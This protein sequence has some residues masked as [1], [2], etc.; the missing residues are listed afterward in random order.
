MAA[1][2]ITKQ[3]PPA[4]VGVVVPA[5]LAQTAAD[6]ANGNSFVL[7]GRE[8]LIIQNTDVSS[9]TYTITSAAD[10]MGR[11]S[12]IGPI[13]LAAGVIHLLPIFGLNGWGA[14]GNLL[15]S[16]NHAGVK[17]SVIQLP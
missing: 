12:D 11:T 7:T 2:A 13:T 17:F 16:A 6:V 4:Q 9:H 3:N 1:T 10:D 15:L 14:G 8:G 5:V